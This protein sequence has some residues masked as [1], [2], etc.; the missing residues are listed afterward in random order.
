MLEFYPQIKA[1]HVGLVFASIGLFVLRGAFALL[2]AR[3]V[4]AAPLRYLSYGID[5]ALLTAALM[6]LTILPGEIFANHWLSAKLVLLLVYVVLGSIALRRGRSTRAR[7]A[8]Y[9]AAVAVVTMMV[10][11]ARTH[12]PLGWFFALVN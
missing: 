1:V 4:M 5:T 12:Q 2:G 9:L 11:I 8:A 7:G 10:G 3:W 6:L